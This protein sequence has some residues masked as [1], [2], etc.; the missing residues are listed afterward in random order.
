MSV[1]YI[2]LGFC[3]LMCAEVEVETPTGGAFTFKRA[4]VQ[5]SQRSPQNAVK[6]Y[7]NALKVTF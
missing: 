4:D 6:M 2:H 5:E 7:N 3:L 1:I